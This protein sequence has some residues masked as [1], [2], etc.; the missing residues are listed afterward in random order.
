MRIGG[1]VLLVAASWPALAA[2][3]TRIH[4]PRG[5]SGTTWSGTIVDGEHRFRL[6][7]AKGQTLVVGGDDVYTW[8]AIAPDRKPLGCDGGDYCVPND[9]KMVLPLSGNYVVVTDYR[10]T[11]CADCKAEK[12]RKVKVTFEAK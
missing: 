4:F 8:S 11:G 3:P 10:M 7:L 9:G 2:E 5:A 1:F 12:T 6:N